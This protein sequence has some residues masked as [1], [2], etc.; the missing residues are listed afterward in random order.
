MVF[1]LEQNTAETQARMREIRANLK[2]ALLDVVRNYHTKY[3]EY[4]PFENDHSFY[5]FLIGSERELYNS[6]RKSGVDAKELAQMVK[7]IAEAEES[8]VES[9]AA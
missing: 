9:A 8:G 2:S 1:N 7:E 4:P 6:A 5:S 3:G